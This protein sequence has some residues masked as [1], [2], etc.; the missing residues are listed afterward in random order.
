M[1]NPR[2]SPVAS[3]PVREAVRTENAPAPAG[4]YSQAIKSGGFIF[5]SGQ[6]PRRPDGERALEEPFEIQAELVMQ[7][8]AAIAAAAGSS[9]EDAVQVTVYLKNPRNSASFDAVYRTWIGNPAPSRTLVQSSLIVGEL[10]V[11]AVLAAS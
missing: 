11:S 3:A 7:N 5:V 1:E 9:L 6:T 2:P 10:E 8:L 4:S